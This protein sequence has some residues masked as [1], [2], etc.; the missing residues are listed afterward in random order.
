M[1]T[2]EAIEQGIIR[3]NEAGLWASANAQFKEEA[4]KS[5]S[6]RIITGSNQ[7]PE[8]MDFNGTKVRTLSGNRFSVHME[9][10]GKR[11]KAEFQLN[12]IFVTIRIADSLDDVISALTSYAYLQSK[13]PQ[14]SISIL[15]AIFQL[16]QAGLS[17]HVANEPALE[18]KDKLHTFTIH[19]Q[20]AQWSIK[21]HDSVKL[22][23]IQVNTLQTAV[24]KV[25]EFYDIQ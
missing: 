12:Q 24:N 20:D 13:L 11:Y 15:E 8:F 14:D 19:W 3:L 10:S 2:S 22:A 5:G 9:E 6:S 18:A 23:A 4:E 21:V 17:T 16:K 25:I 1:V 7:P